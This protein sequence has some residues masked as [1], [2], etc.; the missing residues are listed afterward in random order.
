MTKYALVKQTGDADKLLFKFGNVS[1]LE[2]N[3]DIVL[4]TFTEL[5]V[6]AAKGGYEHETNRIR[7]LPPNGKP[8][9]W[10]YDFTASE[11]CV[12]YLE[13]EDDEA[14]KLYFEVME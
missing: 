3:F 12:K 10:F 1:K 5:I 9:D 8:G 6:I 14:A 13:F 11:R 2:G 4:L 7:Y